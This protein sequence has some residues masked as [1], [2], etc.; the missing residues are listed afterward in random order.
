MK[1]S[2]PPNA[3][4]RAFPAAPRRGPGR[5]CSRCS[6]RSSPGST[7][8]RS[9]RGDAYHAA[10]AS[11]S[12]REVVVQPQRGLIVDDQG[13]P[14]VANRTAW[15]VSV[16]RTLLDRL[17]GPRPRGRAQPGRHRGGH[18][19]AAGASRRLV[20]CGDPGSVR[21]RCWNGSPYQPVPVALDVRQSVALRILEQPE[22][23]PG[24]GRPA[25]EPA[26]LPP[27]RTASTSPTSSA[28]SA[29]SP[30]A[31]STTPAS[32]TTPRSTPPARSAGPAS[33]RSTTATCAGSPATSGSP[34]TRWA[35]CSATTARCPAGPATPWSPRSTPR[36]RPPPSEQLADAIRTARG[37]LRP[38]DPPQLPRRLR[39]R[40]RAAGATPAGSSRWPAS[41]RTTPSVWVGGITSK[42]LA[43]ALLREGRRPAARP[44]HPGPVR[45]RLDLEAVHDRRRAQQRLHARAPGSTA[46]RASR[47][48]TG[49]S[50]TTSPS[51]TA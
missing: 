16:D 25:A 9:S 29:R 7:T 14:L 2:T 46:R 37:D 22:D 31:S 3:S 44:G 17:S 45:A 26:R 36:C 23:Y 27:A 8:S 19:A 13:R 18:A 20:T 43:A 49:C 41:R 40:G 50:R 32:T 47:S 10:A 21:G 33:S 30:P 12:L 28:T 4:S 1:P 24:G 11:Q 34:S 48:A 51:P 5:W 39:R 38:G 6:P 42:Q 15:V 35:G